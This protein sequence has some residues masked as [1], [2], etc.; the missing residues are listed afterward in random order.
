[1]RENQLHSGILL[2][3]TV[4]F[5][6]LGPVEAWSGDTR[7]RLGGPLQERVLVALLLEPNR[8]VSLTRLIEATWDDHPPNTATHQIRKIIADLRRRL[9][10]GPDLLITDGAGYRAAVT[11]EQL[12]VTLFEL[13]LRRAREASA[14]DLT[15]NA[16][17]ELRAGLD[18]WRGPVLGGS[19]G[20]VISA[21]ASVLDERRLHAVEQWAELSLALGRAADVI[22]DLRSHVGQYPLRESLRAKLMLALYH[23][24]RQ[25]EALEEYTAARRLLAEELGVDPGSELVRI[26]EGILQTDP[27]L[28]APAPPSD[29]SSG[30]GGGWSVTDS[31]DGPPCSL[32]HDL[33]DFTGRQRELEQLLASARQDHRI[34]IT[35]ISGMG[36]SGKTSLALRAAHQ[37]AHLYPDGQ[38]YIDL[39]GFTPGRTPMEPGVALDVMMRTLGVPS[40]RIPDDPPSLA[41]I[42]RVVTANRRLLI[43]LDNAADEAQVQS[44]LPGSPDSMVIITSRNRLVELDGAEVIDNGQLTPAESAAMLAAILGTDRIGAEPDAA[45]SLADLC[46]H[47]PLALRI[48]AARLRG[49][50]HWRIADLVRRLAAGP[51]PLQEL[52]AGARSVAA[53]IAVS[54]EAVPSFHRQVLRRLGAHPGTDFD[55]ESAAALCGIS[56]PQA[57]AALEMLLDSALIEQNRPLRYT[58]HDLVGSFLHDL[59]AEPAHA[60]EQRAARR[61]LLDDYLI[62]SGSAAQLLQPGQAGLELTGDGTSAHPRINSLQAALQWYDAERHNLLAAVR[63]AARHGFDYHAV[64]LPRAMANYLQ[65]RGLIRDAME[66]LQLAVE[67][68]R[69]LG[70]RSLEAVSLMNL[71]APLWHLGSPTAALDRLDE[72]LAIATELGDLPSQADCLARAGIQLNTL[73]NYLEGLHRLRLALALHR[74]VGNQRGQ[75][76]TLI[77]MSSALGVVGRHNQSGAAA[78]QALTLS[79]ELSDKDA[80]VMALINSANARNRTGDHTGALHCLRQAQSTAETIGAA[81][82]LA[83]VLTRLTE[84]HL[85][86]GDY[87]DTFTYGLLALEQ[88]RT[89]HRPAVVAAVENILGQAHL[90]RGE[91]A[92]ALTRHENA[93]DAATRAEKRIEQARALTGLAEAADLLGRSAAALDYAN[94]A[95]YHFAEMGVPQPASLRRLLA[96]APRV[97]E[98]PAQRVAPAKSLAAAR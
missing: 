64:Q 54:Y 81:D 51:S 84:T 13:R 97:R 12:D 29:R 33:P 66:V 68:A 8:M 76:W 31:A 7:I 94:T 25:A 62:T 69:R 50:T 75:C 74:R 95:A 67:A 58:F 56:V 21:A 40:E 65:L 91:Y 1:M 53:T 93:L 49:R 41:A 48:A 39:L 19:G 52:S 23:S 2:N 85:L 34:N 78:R 73:G 43:V 16:T 30:G 24:G 60:E 82:G 83:L 15:A 89:I 22:G 90:S 61:R 28:A 86:L 5:W 92:P 37:L 10:G 63:L 87:H 47:L 42:W 36:G 20:G 26:H 45:R 96:A 44:L 98:L 57:E 14:Q 72:A 77:S 35:T 70:D 46:G 59:A 79:H 17:D 32:P 80:E 6:I 3:D 71:A 18:L 9:P 55:A 11:E 27:G 38:L 88:A 4:R